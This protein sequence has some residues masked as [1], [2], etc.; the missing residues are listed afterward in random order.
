MTPMK[1]LLETREGMVSQYSKLQKPICLALKRAF[2]WLVEG[3][4]LLMVQHWPV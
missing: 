2:F 1:H 4:M 3:Y